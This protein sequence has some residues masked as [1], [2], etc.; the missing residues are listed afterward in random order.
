VKENTDIT[1]EFEVQSC[2]AQLDFPKDDPIIPRRCVFVVLD[3]QTQKLALTATSEDKYHP[4]KTGLFDVIVT[5]YKGKDSTDKMQMWFWD[6]RDHSLRSYGHQESDAV[7]F[8][9]F[10]KNLVLYR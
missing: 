9:G 10:N 8:E 7:M 3:S 4:R 5:N 6:E 2:V 1:Y